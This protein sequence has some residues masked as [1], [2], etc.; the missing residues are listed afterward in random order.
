MG[1][2]WP[3]RRFTLLVLGAV[4]SIVAHLFFLIKRRD[5]PTATW[6]MSIIYPAVVILPSL[7]WTEYIVYRRRLRGRKVHM[8]ERL[9]LFYYG[10]GVWTGFAWLSI[11]V[12]V[13]IDRA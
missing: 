4:L 7:A 1:S 5:D 8:R 13:G 9:L 11:I 12:A 10:L 2:L 3:R 6:T